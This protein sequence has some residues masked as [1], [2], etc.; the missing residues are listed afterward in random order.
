MAK[1]SFVIPTLNAQLQLNSCLKS[2][3]NQNY[4]QNQIEIIIAD[5]GSTDNTLNT[6]KKYNP[7]IIKNTLKTAEAGKAV[8]IKKATGDFVALIDSDNI[9]PHP[10]WLNQMILPFQKQS[11]QISEPW[12][13]TYRKNGGFIER[14]SSLIGANDPYAFVCGIYDRYSTLT[15]NWTS[16][17]ISQNNFKD[18]IL[19]KLE[20]NHIIPTI[21]ANG[22]IYRR[23]FLKKLNIDKYLFDIDLIQQYLNKNQYLYIAKIKTD[24]IHT[25]CES[26]IRKF[27]RKQNRRL[28]D[29]FFYQHQ[30]QFNWTRSNF[31]C[32]PK[33]IVY[34]LTI[35]PCLYHS[36][37]GYFKKPD[38]A[39]FFHPLACLLTLFSF[40][41][42]T[43]KKWLGLL[44]PVNRSSWKQ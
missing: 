20:N 10:N 16:L 27:V 4:P 41:I 30:R 39:W 44:K 25:F 40:G 15:N 35:F 2:I 21:G 43:I 3:R 37:K 32:I 34:T 7:T 26:S 28:T 36:F 33:F 13:F 24:I 1:I 31:I 11:I 38:M 18:F 42:V 8:G 14:Y 12:S 5:G 9:L 6:A 29:Y 23:S 22:T 17:N 19:V